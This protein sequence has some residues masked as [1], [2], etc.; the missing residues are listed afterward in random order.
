MKDTPEVKGW[1]PGAIKPMMSGDGLVVRVRPFCGHLAP[2]Q[3]DGLATLAATYGNGLLDLTS[4]G[5]IQMRGINEA[6]HRDVL[7]AVA[8]LM[9]LD[10]SALAEWRRNVLV[11]PFWQ[12]GDGTETL[13]RAITDALADEAVPVQSP[14][15]G[16]AVDTGRAPVLQTASADIRL[17]RDGDGGLLLV[18]DGADLG[19]PIAP[20]CAAREAMN[21]AQWFLDT[22]TD[23]RRMAAITATGRL[24]PGHTIA[25]QTQTYVPAPGITPNGA[26]V[27]LAFGQLQPETLAM[28]AKSGGLRMTPWRMLLVE[29]P[30]ALPGIEGL[31]TDP[32]D[33]LL[34]VIACTGAPRCVQGHVQTRP[35]ART[36]APH[37]PAGQTLH[38]S[39]CAKGCAHPKSA[40]LT[41]TGS[42]Q[43]LNLIRGG[44]AADPPTQTALSLPD[45]IKA[46]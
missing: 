42:A 20:D 44:R 40:A 12:T 17:E 23:E 32:T 43:G 31:I 9:L 46:I 4:R 45:I 14:K 6:H 33:P 18:A 10:Q 28:L 2:E 1:C 8:R 39:G 36:L 41:I 13:A 3:A 30:R 35:L 34:R 19:K 21:L 27:G 11:T 37:L 7:D 25:R 26:M 29:H 22:R 5:N 16:F 15:F 24:P 38:V